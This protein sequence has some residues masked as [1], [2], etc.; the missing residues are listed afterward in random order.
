MIL[1]EMLNIKNI[2]ITT[3]ALFSLSRKDTALTSMINIG[4]NKE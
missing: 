3:A 2:I 1:Y 4:N